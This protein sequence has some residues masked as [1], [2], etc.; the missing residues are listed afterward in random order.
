MRTA[1][2]ELL[3]CRRI[4]ANEV[5]PAAGMFRTRYR[6]MRLICVSPTIAAQASFCPFFSVS[7]PT[8]WAA[9]VLFAASR[10]ESNKTVLPESAPTARS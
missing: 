6:A 5:D 10:E 7:T 2:L 9:L 1:L 8:P 4:H 3:I